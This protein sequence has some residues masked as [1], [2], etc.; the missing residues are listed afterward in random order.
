M[1][2]GIDGGVSCKALMK[3]SRCFFKE[4]LLD[5]GV[6][7][8]ADTE[9]KAISLKNTGKGSDVF[10]IQNSKSYIQVTPECGH[11]ASN[12]TVHLEAALT[13]L[14]PQTIDGPEHKLVV[15]L[16]SGHHLK[17]PIK[18]NVIEP[19][20]RILEPEFSLGGVTIGAKCTKTLTLENK[21]NIKAVVTADL[22]KHPEFT[23]VANEDTEADAEYSNGTH[24]TIAPGST[25][26]MELEFAP[27]EERVHSFNI[28]LKVSG[29]DHCKGLERQVDAE[30]L[31]PRLL[32]S[33]S[34]IF[35]GSTVINS[36][37]SRK[38]PRYLELRLTNQDPGTL[39]WFAD[40]SKLGDP[41][42]KKQ[43]AFSFKPFKGELQ[44]ND[45]CSVQIGFLPQ[46]A[47]TFNVEIPLY[48]DEQQESP[49]LTITLKGEG[50]LPKLS[51][52]T[53][54]IVLPAV[55]LGMKS[56]ARF[57]VKN[58]GYDSLELQTRLPSVVSERIPLEFSFPAGK[59]IG[60]D[61]PTLPVDVS[62]TSMK[63]VSS[64]IKA[65][66]L[67]A[68]GKSFGIFISAATENCLLTSF[69]FVSQH[70]SI[71]SYDTETTGAVTLQIDDKRKDSLEQVEASP[72][73]KEFSFVRYLNNTSLKIPIQNFPADFISSNG[74]A[75]YEVIEECS[76]KEVKDRP[77]KLSTKRIER[78]GQ[79]IGQYQALIT[80]LTAKGAY[81]HNV[82]PELL[83]SFEEYE[84]A[85][86]KLDEDQ[87]G[88]LSLSSWSSMVYQTIKIFVLN[89]ITRKHI[90][91]LPGIKQDPEAKQVF[92]D[93]RKCPS[94]NIYSYSEQLLLQWM[95][96]HHKKG[97]S[98]VLASGIGGVSHMS[99][100][101]D[102]KATHKPITNFGAD[103]ADG[104]VLCT[105][106]VSHLSSLILP[107]KPLC[108]MTLAPQSDA[109]GIDN[110]NR[111]KHAL[112]M[113]GLTLTIDVDYI[114]T[115]GAQCA[116]NNLL[117]CLYLFDHLPQYIPKAEIS[118]S[119]VL[120]E[121]SAKAIELK[122]PFKFELVYTV[123]IE[124]S[125]DFNVGGA[126]LVI[127]PQGVKRLEVLFQSR[128]SHP[129]E[130][131]LSLKPQISAHKNASTLVFQLRSDVH[132]RKS[133]KTI[134]CETTTYAKQLIDVEVSNP[135]AADSVFGIELIQQQTKKGEALEMKTRKVRRQQRLKSKKDKREPEKAA[136]PAI[137]WPNSFHIS[138]NELKLESNGSKVMQLEFM[139][140]VPGEYRCQ[141]VF[142]D[143]N[144][145]EFVYEI[146]G[147]SKLP[148][149]LEKLQFNM[150][151]QAVNNYVL[152]LPSKNSF[153]ESCLSEMKDRNESDVD[154]KL[155]NYDEAATFSVRF[156]S[157]F[158]KA[159]ATIVLNDEE[160]TKQDKA[161]VITG[162]DFFKE[163]GHGVNVVPFEFRP[164]APGLFPAQ[165]VL[166][167]PS[168]IR[169][170][171]IVATVTAPP[172]TSELEFI[173][174]ARQAI[175]QEIP[176]VNS[177]T[178]PWTLTADLN[179]SSAF[180]GP[181]S[182]VVGPDGQSGVY[183]L[184]FK[185]SWIGKMQGKLLLHNPST[186]ETMTYNLTGH[187][188]EPL[189]EDHVVISCKARERVTH[190]FSVK[191]DSKVEVVYVAESDVPHVSG[192]SELTVP[193][194]SEA[195]YNLHFHPLLGGTYT[196]SLTLSQGEDKPYIWYTIELQVAN[197]E[198]EDVL[199]ISAAVR[200]AVS[201]EISLANPLPH[202]IEFDVAIQGGGL[203]GEEVFTLPPEET[204]AYEL[205]F[206]PL[207]T[208]TYAGSISFRNDQVGEVWYELNLEAKSAPPVSLDPLSCPVG[209]NI[210][211][212]VSLENPSREAIQM[213]TRISNSRNFSIQPS[214]PLLKPYETTQV[215]IVYTPS[216]IGE[217]ESGTI[218][219]YHPKIGEW[220][221]MVSG[222]GE[223]PSTLDP[224][225]IESQVG[226]SV[227][228]TVMFRN[229]F[230]AALALDISAE[231]APGFRLLS[232][233][234][235]VVAQPFSSVM[236]PFS[237]SPSIMRL[238][239]FTITAVARESGM[240]WTLPVQGIVEAPVYG[241][242][243]E[244]KTKCR[245]LFQTEFEVLLHGIEDLKEPEG[246]TYGV[247]TSDEERRLG[248]SVEPCCYVCLFAVYLSVK[249]SLSIRAKQKT[250]TNAKLPLEFAVDFQPLT[251]FTI[252]ADLVVT[253][254]V[255]K[256]LRNLTNSISSES[257]ATGNVE[258]GGGFR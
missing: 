120:G 193:P 214:A 127:E 204:R 164:K 191:N 129:V 48:L 138:I 188:E 181:R 161:S 63:P 232:N 200:K 17:L 159:A 147:L 249:N 64:T 209:S 11:I 175:V 76:G 78:V 93:R 244:F 245:E 21:S 142:L 114:A 206:A 29:V 198:P 99:D 220:R 210:R 121:Q 13:S 149:P 124:G 257:C 174:P 170:Y 157:P 14:S 8:V 189:A 186:N 183:R 195:K 24:L 221:Y 203:L 211:Q 225:T 247:V 258:E 77:K 145:G 61:K 57:M 58:D 165:L 219:F 177:T 201:V 135:F 54:E 116:R 81:L 101:Q 182:L 187:A 134:R 32:L 16:R 52:S 171:A 140:I 136:D 255:C 235:S 56:T 20:I 98:I 34:D 71:A 47:K 85:G 112:K 86:N 45:S 178:E 131:L 254:Y 82:R 215:D 213:K 46:E 148:L 218:A 217:L 103:L 33:A 237:F 119:C 53:H 118:F 176:I 208:G 69:P 113:L 43:S 111:V 251:P 1:R 66:F 246:F 216:S 130:A 194:G 230:P 146:I 37:R 234:S 42:K 27:K 28:P 150:T 151:Y 49:Y 94:S 223:P 153:L 18:A 168:E 166:N 9:K 162:E 104:T 70:S 236:I 163:P 3:A 7:G 72:D 2:G 158:F 100:S 152:K 169:V 95:N 233:V 87:F 197:P 62:F 143:P 222:S 102:N 91:A 50:I 96:Y 226:Q 167:S 67:D 19:D 90:L 238:H 36:L 253:R 139:P 106:L 207:I 224:Q 74:Q 92:L 144:H 23:L 38:K 125:S 89:R 252:Q 256:P 84:L 123:S 10:Y 88:S 73:S 240:S 12:S 44:A 55:P 39:K 180:S 109:Q 122:N 4:K 117:L 242:T 184:S 40:T 115:G 196:G 241:K 108:D 192:D 35:F 160:T 75:L 41:R 59:S 31:R 141:I 107:G 26:E 105:V 80:F 250:L 83:L 110:L 154:P 15:A 68:D 65:E 30:G 126:E 185:P 60:V 179:G 155:E 172:V 229:P 79:L 190:D 239:S 227:S 128:F 22:S 173:T 248:E 137:Q 97:T 156:D 205:I 5:F 231:E 133:T 25:L 6:L 243:F 202:A 132:S 51:F 228:S 199:D 212:S